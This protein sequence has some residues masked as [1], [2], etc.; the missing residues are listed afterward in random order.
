MRR[1]AAHL[2]TIIL[3][4]GLN[5]YGCSDL[6]DKS[7]NMD[8][9]YEMQIIDDQEIGEEQFPE[10]NRETV[11]FTVAIIQSDEMVDYFV[12]HAASPVNDGDKKF[13]RTA[14][15]HLKVSD[16]LSAV[17]N[18]EDVI[19]DKKGFI[20]GSL[21][22]NNVV[23]SREIPVS[24][25]SLL[26]Q[27]EKQVYGKLTLRVHHTL[28][29]ASLREIA[30]LAKEVSFRNIKAEEVTFRIMENKL[31]QARKKDKSTRI[32]NISNPG[33]GHK[34]EDLLSAE[35][36]ID[37]SR[38]AA[39]NALI[40]EYKLYDEIEYSTINISMDEERTRIVEEMK[41]RDKEVKA[42]EPNFFQKI[43]SAFVAGWGI[44]LN[45]FTFLVE[46]WPFVLLIC[47]V[48]YVVVLRYRKKK[49]N[50]TQ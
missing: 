46:I 4:I 28:L 40:A 2:L 5:I 45:I 30:P 6:Y 36:S 32:K 43:G 48:T 26:I 11:Q 13:I 47:L 25:D 33:K 17:H 34:L 7:A 12:S 16:I 10:V 19:I 14:D 24:E 9:V 18:I 1:R 27:T 20:I 3:L 39:D 37:L 50:K 42:Y 23:N 29:D 41:V 38:E 44:V 8:S 15:L 35:E 21:I 49:K 22:R 31:A